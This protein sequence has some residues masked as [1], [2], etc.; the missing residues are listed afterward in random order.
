MC[1]LGD[2]SRPSR[3]LVSQSVEECLCA[4][5]GDTQISSREKTVSSLSSLNDCSEEA[6]IGEEGELRVFAC[7]GCYY[8]EPQVGCVVSNR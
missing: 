3:T 8:Q 5:E 2:M 1:G 4:G 6:N 7:F